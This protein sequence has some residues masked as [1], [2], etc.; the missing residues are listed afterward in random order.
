MKRKVL[1]ALMAMTLVVTSLTS[2]GDKNTKQAK[3]TENH[4]QEKHLTVGSTTGFFG[5][6]SLDPAYNWDSWLMSIYGITENLFRLDKNLAP[7]PWLCESYK[8]VDK[9]HWEL[10][11]RDDVNFSDGTKMTAD[12]VKKCFTRT[13]EMNSR[14]DETVSIKSMEA[15]GQTLKIETSKEEPTLLNDLCD[16]LMAVYDAEAKV[17]KELGASCT[18]PFVATK[19]ESMV[20]VS[21]KKNEQYW[22]GAVALD[23]LDLKIIDDN[24]ALNM[25][26]QNGEIDMIAQLPAEGTKI[27]KDDDA[28]TMEGITSTRSHFLM[29]NQETIP[30]VNVRKALN[31]CIDRE[32]YANVIFNGYAEPCYG[33]YPSM[34]SFGKTDGTNKEESSLDVKAAKALLKEAG[35]EDKDGDGIVEKDGKKLSLKFVTYSY[36]NQLLQF[37]DMYQAQLKEAGVELKIETFDVLDDVMAKKDYDIAGLSYAIAPTGAEPYFVNMVFVPKG[38]NNYNGYNNNVVTKEAKK[39]ATTY[40]REKRDAIMETITKEVL[41]DCAHAFMV[42]QQFVCVYN[43]KVTGFEINPSEY[44]LI[45]NTLGVK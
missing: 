4:S 45:T 41:N 33:V 1:A 5:A 30:D 6:E 26:L 10:T 28:F 12:A 31:R 43:K 13:R 7:K 22:G 20:E 38:S 24:D 32:S 34:L 2:C 14:F 11:L 3:K 8:N 40:D 39:L 19:F 29:F 18:G 21:L 16:P 42:N 37:A 17:D 27:F 44:Y 36:N 9:T 35:Y 23:T 25:A 15:D